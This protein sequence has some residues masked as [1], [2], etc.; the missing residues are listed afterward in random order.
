MLAYSLYFELFIV[1]SVALVLLLGRATF[2]AASAARKRGGMGRNQVNMK[3]AR[4]LVVKTAEPKAMSSADFRRA[5]GRTKRW[6]E[7]W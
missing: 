4:K 6:K 2:R 1:L 7:A 5:L 3:C